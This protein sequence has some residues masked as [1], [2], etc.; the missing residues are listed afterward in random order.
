MPE[1][2]HLSH[3]LIILIGSVFI[4][5]IGRDLLIPFVFALFIWFLIK[6]IRISINRVAFIKRVFPEW[7]KNIVSF[8]VILLMI[9]FVI[10]I[11]YANF[12]KLSNSIDVYMAKVDDI[13]GKINETF[14]IDVM[15]SLYLHYE[16]YN[17]SSFILSL[18]NYSTGLVG[19]I[20]IIVVYAI[21]ILL[22][23]STF[24]TKLE[25]L[26]PQA[27]AYEEQFNLIKKIEYAVS[28]YLGLKTLICLMTSVLS[29]FALILIGVDFPVFWAFLIFILNYIPIIGSYV[30]T[31]LPVSFALLQFGSFPPAIFVLLSVGTIQLVIGNFIDPRIMGNNVNLS[32]LVII[33]SLSFWGAVWG[34]IGMFLSVPLMIIVLI[35][36]A[37]IPRFQPLAIL[38][39][40]NG[41]I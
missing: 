37:K 32:P 1:Y 25:K 30:A 10:N 39:S 23:E 15:N 22:E 19:T 28:K 17:M 11:V 34:V 7:L 27:E 38:M 31:F 29:Y 13:I 3:A 12:L 2:K 20:F 9:N 4:L 36:F 14:N 24:K 41:E 5:Y 6:Q 33:F 18:F 35:V 16:D 21:F 26:L 8:L 40:R